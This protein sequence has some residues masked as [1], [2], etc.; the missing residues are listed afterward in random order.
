[1][2]LLKLLILH[3]IED[4]RGM[5]SLLKMM[6]YYDFFESI[7][8]IPTCTFNDGEAS[9]KDI[10]LPVRAVKV[11][12]NYYNDHHGNRRQEVVMN[13]SIEA[14]LPVEIKMNYEGMHFKAEGNSA[15]LRVPL[16]ESEL[17]YYYANYKDYFYLPGEDQAL[18]KSIAAF[19]DKARRTQATAATCYTRK[20]S[21]YLRE[22]DLIF[23]PFFKKDYHDKEL[24]FELDD[25]IKRSRLAMSLY[26]AHII[27]VMVD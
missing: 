16:L 1:A 6:S 14:D 27:S 23:T 7:K 25:N 12:A 13:L 3:N 21:Q 8:N 19:V 2:D 15:M 18:H 17:K 4:L 22:W 11:G 26:A 24:Y 10:N 9:N 5:L 20:F